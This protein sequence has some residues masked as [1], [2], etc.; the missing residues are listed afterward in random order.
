MNLTRILALGDSYT[1]GEGVN[2]AESFPYILAELMKA[3]SPDSS[4]E[5]KVVAKTGW[6]TDELG[7]KIDEE[8]KEGN[9]VLEYS[10]V[11]LLIGV[12][13]QYRGPEKGYNQERYEQEFPP[14]LEKAL[15]FA[16]GQA[17]KVRVLSI[18][19]WGKTPFGRK[20]DR[21]LTLVSKEIDAYNSFASILCD[22]KNVRF[23]DIT[24]YSRE[25]AADT[26]FITED[27]LHYSGKSNEHYAQVVFD[28]L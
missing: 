7:D 19:D 14:L 12:N 22:S 27:G 10:L 11:T 28:S 15:R 16:G 25:V 1:I 9:F 6:T 2:E 23:L 5:V 3:K 17:E 13:N 8:E 26:S 20:S 24:P 4:L 21:D 18:P